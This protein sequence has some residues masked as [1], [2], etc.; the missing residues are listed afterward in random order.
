M[1]VLEDQEF[2]PER[3]LALL[4]HRLG[5][6]SLPEFKNL[7]QVNN[8]GEA[9]VYQLAKKQLQ[10]RYGRKINV[11]LER[12]KFYSRMQQDDELIDQFVAALRG[13]AVTCK[14]EQ[15][16]Y[17]QV[18]RDRILMKTKS[19]KIQ[20]KLWSCSGDQMLR[21]AIDAARTIEVSEKC[22]QAV[23]RSFNDCDSGTVAIS[24]VN[25]DSKELEKKL[26]WKKNTA[27]KCYR[28]GAG[29]H[30][31][32]SKKCPA[33]TKICN[34]CKNIGHFNKVCKNNTKGISYISEHDELDDCR[35]Q[36]VVLSVP[37]DDSNVE[38]NLSKLPT[39]KL[40]LDTVEV[41]VM[42]DSCAWFTIMNVNMFKK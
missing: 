8:A 41:T 34:A 6:G 19:R 12:Y 24:S 37:E 32:H 25:K 10:E 9:D 35:I 26:D 5:V 15:I 3:Y 13:I 39:C 42:V 27:M 38:G 23:R 11:V 29:D 20:E 30:L 14:F 40:F 22:V 2:S 36:E 1:E 31:A 7:L 33:F 28:C 4:K 16:S 17:D 18:L 21:G